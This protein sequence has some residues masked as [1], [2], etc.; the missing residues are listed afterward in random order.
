MDLVDL[1]VLLC[2]IVLFWGLLIMFNC[3]D[4]SFGVENVNN[5]L[6]V[7]LVICRLLNECFFAFLIGYNKKGDNCLMVSG[8]FVRG[9]GLICVL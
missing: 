1:K 4:L 5:G 9:D 6:V 2:D 7:F 8:S 3:R